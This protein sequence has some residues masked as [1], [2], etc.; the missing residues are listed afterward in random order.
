MTRSRYIGGF[1]GTET[2]QARWLEEKVEGCRYLVTN[3]AGVVRRH[4]QT[5]YTGL[6]KSLL[7]E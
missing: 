5:A 2:A 3:L 7:K 4:P 6:H 1:V